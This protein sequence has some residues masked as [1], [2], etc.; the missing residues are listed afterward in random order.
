MFPKCHTFPKFCLKKVGH[1][2]VTHCITNFRLKKIFE[3]FA[4]FPNFSKFSHSQYMLRNL[5]IFCQYS[6]FNYFRK[7]PLKYAIFPTLPFLLNISTIYWIV[8]AKHNDVEFDNFYEYELLNPT[9]GEKIQSPY[10]SFLFH[11][12][13]CPEPRRL[14]KNN[15]L[16]SLLLKFDLKSIFRL[17]KLY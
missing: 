15:R 10:L 16:L 11:L 5:P 12:E 9:D 1:F 14:P 17:D 2:G 7:F 6:N 13:L 8:F 4:V 3:N